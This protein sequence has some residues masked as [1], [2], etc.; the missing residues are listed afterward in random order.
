MR[1]WGLEYLTDPI[2][3]TKRYS[4]HTGSRDIACF[5][6][7]LLPESRQES[8]GRALARFG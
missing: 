8:A 2:Q 3:S 6:G 1:V 5:L 7:P 4:N